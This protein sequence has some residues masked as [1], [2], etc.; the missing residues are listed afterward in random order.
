MGSCERLQKLYLVDNSN[1]FYAFLSS[2]YQSYDQSLFRYLEMNTH[3]QKCLM[4][5]LSLKTKAV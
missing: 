2:I 4:A 1:N 5:F 3:A